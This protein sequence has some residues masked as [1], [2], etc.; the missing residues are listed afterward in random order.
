MLV[1]VGAVIIPNNICGRCWSR[2]YT[3]QQCWSLLE[4]LLY[5]TTFLVDAGAVVILNS[6]V[7]RYATGAVI[8]LNNIVGRYWS[9]YYTKQHGW[10][11]LEPL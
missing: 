3:R 9:R 1:A 2:Y 8:I 7:G 5:L 11:L 10:S 4:P 6:I